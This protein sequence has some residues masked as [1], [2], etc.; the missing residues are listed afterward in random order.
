[1]IK[2]DVSRAKKFLTDEEFDQA[3]DK[4]SE[5]LMTVKERNGKGAEWLGWR[6][7]L[8]DPNDAILEQLHSM[9]TKI[10]ENADVFIVCGIGGSYLGARAVI[11]ALAS[12]FGNK[13][14][15]IIY[16]G[17]HMSGQ[18]LEELLAY[19]EE[20]T[21]DGEPKS[22]YCNVISKSGTTLETALSFRFIR[23]WMQDQY[24]DTLQDRIICTTSSVGGALNKL[25]DQY[26]FQKFVIPDDVGGRFSVLT[27]VGLLPI[28][29]A[30]IDIRSLF[31]GAVSKY[32]ELEE[33]AGSLLDYAAVKYALFKKGKA[34]DV[35]TSFEPQLASLGGW[36]QQLLGESEGKGGEGMF[37]AVTTYST[38][39]HSLGQ[40]I[41]DG[42][43]IV[44]ET[45]ITVGDS[46]GGLTVKEA[47]ENNDGLNYLAG[48][49]FHEINKRAFEGTIQ[50]HVKGGVPS[51]VVNLDKLNAQ[52]LGEF[53]YLYELFTAVYC[54]SLNVNPFNQPGVEDYKSEMYQLLGK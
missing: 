6:D 47:E 53:I 46:K 36:L 17:H 40:F 20:L 21:K 16:A 12:F 30:G 4:A 22:V 42:A 32:E 26:R 19:L 8:S 15:E 45:F 54:Y 18:Y 43:R 23:S 44:M 7:L 41:Q 49:T 3:R 31:Y 52:H 51:V 28:A 35:I 27:P 48:M 29:V 24:P 33:E 25:V 11:D 9:A 38:D 13:G 1:M 14:P 5:A 50:A 2:L 34:V 10:R 39:L 37:P